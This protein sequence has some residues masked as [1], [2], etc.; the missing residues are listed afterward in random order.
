[1]VNLAPITA[2]DLVVR[3]IAQSLNIREVAGRPLHDQL[4]DYLH[5]MH[6]LL[7]DNFE[8]VVSAAPIVTDLLATCP[9]LT[10]LVT[11]RATLHMRGEKALAVPPLALPDLKRVLPLFIVRVRDVHHD[12]AITS[13]NAPAV[14]AICARLD[15]LPLAIELAARIKLLPPQALLRQLGDRLTL[16]TGGA[17]DL[18]QRQQTLRR[19]I[20]WSYH[21]LDVS[22]QRLFARPGVFVGG[23]ALKAVAAVCSATP[24]VPGDLPIAALDGLTAL[25]DQSLLRQEV[26]TDGAPRFVMLET[27]RAYALERLVARGEEA[28]LRQ[29]HAQ[30]YL[31]LVE[32][33]EA[34]VH[35]AEQLA[36]VHRSEAERDNQRAVLAWSQVAVDAATVGLRIVAALK[37]CWQFGGRLSEGR[38]QLTQML[39]LP[40]AG[41]PT[42][43]RA[44]ALFTAG[45]LI[46]AQGDFALARAHLTESQVLSRTL[47]YPQGV[48]FARLA[49]GTWPG[50]RVSIRPPAHCT[51]RA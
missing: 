1:M 13:A 27:I 28:A 10:I 3:M 38:E 41:A 2:A 25:V 15:G 49:W 5:D 31:A 33:A 45:Y 46:G 37:S 44:R 11:S 7:L 14:A 19:T 30:Y 23:G 42:V 32:R 18:P 39:E 43:A 12:F 29:R 51:P 40:E 6:L 22:E 9:R 34:L 20:D 35:G 26:G 4:H 50:S 17:R 21:L 36:W 8:Q 16:I 24:E 47:G 48:A